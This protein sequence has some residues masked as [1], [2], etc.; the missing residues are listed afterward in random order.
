ML[1][2]TEIAQYDYEIDEFIDILNDEG[3]LSYL[4]IG[5]QYGGSLWRVANSLPKGSR[6]VSVDLP[7]RGD[8]ITDRHL[9]ECV[10]ALCDLGYN[11][12]VI[13]GNSSDKEIVSAA[14]RDGPFDAVF[15]DGCHTLSGVTADWN[16]YGPHGRIVAFHDIAWDRPVRK[17]RKPIE[18]AKLWRSIKGD[19][20][21]REI[22]QTG[23]EIEKGIGVLWR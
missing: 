20:R 15:I 5:S 16:N 21:H 6:I 8:K 7:N 12:K 1:C 18:V 19:Y 3:C 9:A 2:Q 10:T 22:V 11:A 14:L 23:V 13:F 17:G 4:E